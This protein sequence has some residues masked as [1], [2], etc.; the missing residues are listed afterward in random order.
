MENV[1]TNGFY[2]YK[3]TNKEA[4]FLQEELLWSQK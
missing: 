2:L 4:F 3:D 1:C